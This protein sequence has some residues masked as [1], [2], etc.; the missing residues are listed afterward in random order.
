M[1]KPGIKSTN[2]LLVL[3]LFGGL[4]LPGC[5]DGAA[6]SP[7]RT[8]APSGTPDELAVILEVV[9]D[10]HVVTGQSVGLVIKASNGQSL[11]NVMWHVDT[12]NEAVL[13]PHSQAIGFDATIPGT[14]AWRVSATLPDKQRLSTTGTLQVYDDAPPVVVARLSQQAVEL[15]DVSL[16]ADIPGSMT[17]ESIS[18]AQT[19]GPTVTQSYGSSAV[20]HEMYFQ[21][22]SVDADTLLAFEVTA[23]FED[24][25]QAQ[26]TVW[27]LVN[28]VASDA[29][30]YFPSNELYPTSLVHPY[31]PNGQWAST[32]VPCT[33]TQILARS[34][35][36][37]KLPLLG[38]KTATP[39]IDDV[40]A[41]TV[42]S[43]DWMGDA[44]AEFLANSEA[45]DDLLSLLGATTAIVIAHDIRPSFYWS[46]TGAIYLDAAALW[47]SPEE[48]DSINSQ[49]DPR[50]QFD[51]GLDY[52]TSWRL[53]SQNQ[54]YFPLPGLSRAARQARDPSQVAAALTYLLYHELAHANDVF[55]RASWSGFR[56]DDSPLSIAN[57][58]APLSQS[59]DQDYP[60]TNEK[61]RELA[62]VAFG[63]AQASSLQRQ[64]SAQQVAEWFEQ[65]A[66]VS[67]Y[68]YFSPQE[69]FAMLFQAFM[70]LHRLGVET[71]VGFFTR[72]T[73]QSGEQLISWGQRN[74]VNAPHIQPRAAFVVNQLLPGIDIPAAQNAAPSPQYLPVNQPWRDTVSL[75]QRV[76]SIALPSV[77]I[78]P[79]R[80]PSHHIEH[81][82]PLPLQ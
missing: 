54:N 56:A 41:R 55:P 60:L 4:A 10:T 31:R 51:E 33:Y 70:L 53:V 68:S 18:W 49:P 67:P 39:T 19:Q 35:S 62:Q 34:C 77:K 74:R 82:L 73:V 8:S 43:H 81:H 17:A 27:V 47:R 45:Q 23:S 44:F 6:D 37:E 38:Q 11:N 9:G 36:F 59:L 65:D 25:S 5:G 14:I 12:Y 66:A 79:P 42:V 7:A 2:A 13:A 24:G 48:R 76:E 28:D 75:D 30:A 46:A 71:D 64:Y 22:P 50:G 3:A 21:A 26:D 1:N 69:D 32:L 57:S 15:G 63:G 61:L 72:D 52:R 16:R 78:R 20:A 80:L 29:A 40:L 58:Q